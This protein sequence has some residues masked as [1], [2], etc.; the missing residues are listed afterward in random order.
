MVFYIFMSKTRFAPHWREQIDGVRIHQGAGRVRNCVR[1]RLKPL[2]LTPIER[3][4]NIKLCAEHSQ[5][6]DAGCPAQG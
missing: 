3:K 4:K 6:N 1:Y 5:R 2:R